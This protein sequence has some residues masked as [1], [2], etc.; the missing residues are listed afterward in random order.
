ME[1]ECVNGLQVAKCKLRVTGRKHQV[2]KNRQVKETRR[3]F[4]RNIIIAGGML[5]FNS[6]AFSSDK[7]PMHKHTE[8]AS[9]IIYRAVN[10][11]PA[12]NLTKVIG[13]IGGIEKIIGSNDVALIKPNVRWW[14]Q[15]A[16][17]L[18]ALKTFVDLIMER[19]GG[20]NGE[21][22]LFE[23]CHQGPSPWTSIGAG[24]AHDFERN[25]EITNVSNYNE[26]SR[27]LKGKYKEKFSVCHLIDIA[28][29]NRRVYGPSDGSG[30]VYCDGSK[31]VPLIQ[32][33]NGASG[34]NHRATIMT[35]PIF[36][37]D[38]GT[39]IDFKN[40]IWKNG[41]YTGQPLRFINFCVLNY[42]TAFCGMTSAIKNYMGITDLSGGQDPNNGGRLTEKYYN[43]HSFAFNKWSPGPVPGMLGKEIGTFM[44][45]IRKADLNI[46]TAEWIGLSSRTD[47]PLARTRAVLASADP[48]ALDYH[49]A[50]YILF[51]NSKLEIHNPDN[52]KSPPH[53]YLVKCAE[54]GGGIFDERLVKVTSYDF[55]TK[56]L[57]KDDDMIVSGETMWG[58]N[59]KAIL[60]YLVLRYWNNA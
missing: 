2:K 27:I 5:S 22:V 57:Q 48:V 44:K 6:K 33:E 8:N 26:L 1:R 4:L 9:Q 38:K 21:V 47:S 29:G 10:G 51:P 60:K 52:K 41:S 24:W 19:V 20:F 25:S 53:Q 16:S 15:G 46:T 45:T 28:S 14:N 39:A 50:K 11:T 18:L 23:N 35:Y 40:G 7:S 37:T 13:L 49:A 17:N 55:K 30:Y 56:L 36:R 31:G 34:S 42:H 12:E 58:T 3:E 43:F 59:P 54:E 32:C